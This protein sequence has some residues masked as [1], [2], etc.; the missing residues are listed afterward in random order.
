MGVSRA[1]MRE[2]A[3]Y[4][5][6]AMRAPLLDAA[7][8]VHHF[9]TRVRRAGL[10]DE[11]PEIQPSEVLTD[12]DEG[13]WR[14]ALSRA[15]R[16]AD[17]AYDVGAAYFGYEGARPFEEQVAVFRAS[18]PGYSDESYELAIEAGVRAMR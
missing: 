11:P 12:F 14:D 6:R 5:E 1:D 13:P 8:L 17:S 16:L 10:A 15:V 9:N 7:F 4:V 3:T 18:N 2:R